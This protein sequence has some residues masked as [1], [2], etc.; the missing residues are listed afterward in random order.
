VTGGPAP[1][2]V[3]VWWVDLDVVERASDDL[4][5]DER[6]RVER[7]VPA[8]PRR[9]RAAR[10]AELRRLLARYTGLDPASLPLRAGPHGKPEC[11][12]AA[13]LGFNCSSSGPLAVYAFGAGVRVGVDLEYRADGRFEEMPVRRYMTERERSTLDPV[14]TWVVKEAVAKGIGVGFDLP[15]FGIELERLEPEP[16]V[17]LTGEWAGVDDASW[18]VRLL[19]DD[20]RVG[21]IA[22]DAPVELRA[23]RD[24]VGVEDGLD[25]P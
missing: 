24:P 15:P 4:D 17:R 8:V 20:R 3:E 23:R 18:H 19:G 6:A 21:A 16:A 2:T 9:R 7:V 14:R 11:P 10:R 5:A 25:V 1:G 13:G 12:A 22:T